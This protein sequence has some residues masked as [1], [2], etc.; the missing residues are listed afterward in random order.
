MVFISRLAYSKKN[1]FG[2][3]AIRL[4]DVAITKELSKSIFPPCLDI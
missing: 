1:D 2:L 4:P 3:L